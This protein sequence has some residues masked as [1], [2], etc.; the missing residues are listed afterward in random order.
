MYKNLLYKICILIPLMLGS[1]AIAQT[2]G[3]ITGT[4]IEYWLRAD[5]VSATLPADGANVTTWQD[6]STNGR[7]FSNTE[8]NPFFPKFVK[9]AMNYHSSVDFYFLSTEEGGPSDANNRRRK[10]IVNNNSLVPASNKSYFVIW[11]SKLDQGNSASEAT[12]FG[13]NSAGSGSGTTDGNQYGWNGEYGRLWHRTQGTAYTHNSTTERSYGIGVAVLPNNS[14]TA[15]QQYLNAL[16]S[17][18]SMPARTLGTGT[19]PSVIGTSA[20]DTG[21]ERYFFG[22]VME[23]I[24]LSKDGAGN[25]LTYDELKKIN[26][27]LAIKYGITLNVA[28]TDYL[29]SNGT[30]V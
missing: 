1:F 19:N 21:Y 11:I 12:I 30:S 17:G 7:N 6:L 3:G 24:V 27:H 18:T 4:N 23:I 28:Q 13:L 8:S 2:P 20:T 29:L 22:E 14:S 25:T 9:S 15:Q 16:A 26:S 5:Q 10:L